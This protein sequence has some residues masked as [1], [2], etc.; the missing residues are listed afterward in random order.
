MSQSAVLPEDLSLDSTVGSLPLFAVSFENTRLGVELAD[1]FDRDPTL[2]GVILTENRQFVSLVSRRQF[3]EYLLLPQGLDLFLDNPLRVF[4]RYNRS[5]ILVLPHD[6]PILVAMQRALRR[7]PRM[8]TEPL[9]VEFNQS[10]HQVL[11]FAQL[12]LSAWQLRGIETQVRYERSQVRMVQS[13]RMAMLGRLVD[14]IAHEI[15]DP[16][17]FIWGN[18][19][20]VARYSQDLLDLIDAYS[21]HIPNPPPSLAQLRADLETDYIQHDLPKAVK[22]ITTG[23]QRLRDLATSLQNFCHVDEVYPKPADINNAIESIVLLLKTR[24]GSE[25]QLIK[26]YGNL[27]PVP[28][29]IGQLTQVLVNILVNAVDAL[30]NDAVAL[31]IRRE[32]EPELIL[33]NPPQIV[34]TTAVLSP[35]A[36][37]T[38]IGGQSLRLDVK[39]WVLIQIRDNGPGMTPRQKRRLRESFSIE[40]R[41]TK[42]NSLALAYQIITAKHGGYL[43]FDSEMKQGTVFEI[44]LPLL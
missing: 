11:D 44:L 12:S 31:K 19:T 8:S 3:L 17:G 18:L 25:I 23:A 7:Q 38:K 29:Y 30:L 33:D 1:V 40:R 37:Q 5:E 39:R 24:L 13:E 36:A 28:C 21:H 34:I 27:P 20:H 42:E 22:S 6:M 4:F 10:H 32:L 16:V 14:G 41:L 9:V 43:C 35:T 26:E 2:P 15:L